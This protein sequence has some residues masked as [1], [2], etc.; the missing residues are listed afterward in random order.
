MDSHSYTGKRT[1]L[2]DNQHKKLL[3]KGLLLYDLIFL[4]NSFRLGEHVFRHIAKQL[5]FG[6]LRDPY[7]S[8]Q[9]DK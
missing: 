8:L 6:C 5:E 9:I 3:F 7:D 2:L 4:K 1:I